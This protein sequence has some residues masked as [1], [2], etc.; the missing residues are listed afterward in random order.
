MSLLI[1][2][3]V[4]CVAERNLP[5]RQLVENVVHDWKL[6]LSPR[7]STVE[8]KNVEDILN[9]LPF[10]LE[11]VMT[12]D[13][14]ETFG[15]LFQYALV[16]G[17]GNGSTI[18]DVDHTV[19]QTTNDND[20]LYRTRIAQMAI[21]WTS[22]Q[23]AKLDDYIHSRCGFLISLHDPSTPKSAPSANIKVA[24]FEDAVLFRSSESFQPHSVPSF[25]FTKDYG[26]T[27]SRNNSSAMS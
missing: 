13:H 27:L 7:Y 25:F 21:K 4:S 2:L 3:I 11:Y 22:L 23:N 9:P 5:Q 24:Y 14:F 19:Y 17:E 15:S 18:L 6:K 16:C 20:W 10:Q 26:V 1:F 8:I 12:A